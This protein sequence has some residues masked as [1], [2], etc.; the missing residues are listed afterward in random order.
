MHEAYLWLMAIVMA[1]SIGSFLN[2]VIYRLP[3][4]IFYPEEGINVCFPRSHCPHCKT[5]IG[6]FDNIPLFSWLLL[7]GKCRHCGDAISW[8]Y[9][10]VE[11]LTGGVS[12]LLIFFLPA[13]IT[14]LA[15]L[16]FVWVLLALSF[17][18]LEHQLL[19]DALTLPLL[20]TGLLCHAFSL[21]PGSLEEGVMGA[22]AGYLTFRLLSEGWR[23]F[24]HIE[25]L[26]RGD[27]KLLA[28]L[29]AWLGWQALPVLLLVA[30]MGCIL[31]MLIVS[32]IQKTSLHRTVAFGP[33]LSL[34]G[35]SV[36][37]MSIS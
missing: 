35:A 14:L 8:R 9:P 30:S 37:F 32:G 36:F 18:D 31:S 3:R 15:A 7:K 1:I 19:P 11:L 2:V 16:F 12:L 4:Q 22:A 28:A 20:W 34:A 33:W 26:G 21:L 17:I 27:A 6:W 10:L 29:G 24:R 13:D 23:Q 25:A 5:T